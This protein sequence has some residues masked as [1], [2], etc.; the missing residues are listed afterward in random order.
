MQS[1]P[2]TAQLYAYGPIWLTN[3]SSIE[4][5]HF[6]KLIRFIAHFSCRGMHKAL[7]TTAV[8]PTPAKVHLIIRLVNYLS[9]GALSNKHDV[10]QCSLV[11]GAKW[12]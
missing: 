11:R 2:T 10:S 4:V 6:S 1:R 8:A 5:F 9:N 7:W 12:T 3:N